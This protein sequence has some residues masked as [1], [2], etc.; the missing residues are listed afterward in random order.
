[1][2]KPRQREPNGLFAGTIGSSDVLSMCHHS[3][4][5]RDVQLLF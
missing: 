1:M 3:Q 5:L 2:K 4:L